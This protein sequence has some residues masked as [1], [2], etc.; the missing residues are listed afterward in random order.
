M[1]S[2]PTMRS[3]FRTDFVTRLQRIVGERNFEVFEPHT[4]RRNTEAVPPEPRTVNGVAPEITLA[5]GSADEV[6]AVLQMCMEEKIPVVPLGSGLHQNIGA[7]PQ[8]PFIA[9]A[10][11]RLKEVEHYD[12]GDLTI[13]VG[14]GMA[15][16]ELNELIQLH[17]QWL[18][19][20]GF[21]E[22]TSLGAATVGG[23]LASAMHGPLK[24]AFGGVR[25]FCIG[26]RF[27]TGDGKHG[28]GGGRVVKNVAR[29]DLMKLLIGSY[30]TLGVI[31]SASFKLFP[32]PRHTVTFVCEFATASEGIAFRDR[33]IA[34]P[35]APLTLEVLS[36]NAS[37]MLYGEV[38]S[39][40]RV[41][42]RAGGS[43][44]QMSRYRAEL[45]SAVSAEL[46]GEDEA[47][48]WAAIEDFESKLPAN[49]VL[50]SVACPISDVAQVIST[51]ERTAAERGLHLFC[52]GCV[53][54]G[55][56]TI[57]LAGEGSQAASAVHSLRAALPP[58]VVITVRGAPAELRASISTWQIPSAELE[59]MRTLKNA[60]DPAWILNRG[61][62]F[63]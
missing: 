29:Y 1:I 26:V 56:L 41:L 2:T 60:L 43:D 27:I 45:G 63:V 14:A 42:I 31:I 57:A 25:E 7:A 44:R 50:L 35:V 5:P 28:K 47:A 20:L 54:V 34:S 48:R 10:T 17:R 12:P 49:N 30:G 18:P 38:D 24:H 33:V 22:R 4:T 61:R 46:T 6:A 40:W 8:S 62:Y 52:V 11:N 39:N 37:R 55:S 16:R 51:A 21:P 59:I 13:G 15:L 19:V 53:G 58:R 32:R 9:I 36:P 3:G 23:V